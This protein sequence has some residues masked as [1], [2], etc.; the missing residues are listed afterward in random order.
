MPG[1]RFS[2]EKK[3][4]KIIDSVFPLQTLVLNVQKCGVLQIQL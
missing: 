1:Y 4:N 3:K 2:C